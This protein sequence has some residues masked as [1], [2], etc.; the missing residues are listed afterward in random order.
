MLRES[1]T[2]IESKNSRIFRGFQVGVGLALRRCAG[3]S[4]LRVEVFIFFGFR[5]R[6]YDGCCE[7]SEFWVLQICGDRY[8]GGVF[9]LGGCF[10]IFAD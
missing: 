9:G 5:L 2:I 8:G 10:L 7:Y 3:V 1:L 4:G 6:F